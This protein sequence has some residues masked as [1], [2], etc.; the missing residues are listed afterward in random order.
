MTDSAFK[1]SGVA[2]TYYTS[3]PWG[4]SPVGVGG[5]ASPA[6]TVQAGTSYGVSSTVGTDITFAREDHQHG[7]VP[8]D[9]IVNLSA[10]AFSSGEY[11][12]WNGS[13]FVASSAVL[14]TAVWSGVGGA[15]VINVTPN[16]P[17][18]GGNFGPNTVATTTGG[19]KEAVAALSST[20][21][22]TV[23]VNAGTYNFTG[24]VTITTSNVLIDLDPAAIL[25]LPATPSVTITTNSGGTAMAPIFEVNNASNVW[26]RGGVLTQAASTAAT[27]CGVHIGPNASQVYINGVTFLNLNRWAIFMNGYTNGV[28]GVWSYVYE[29]GNTMTSC[30]TTT[31]PDGGG[32]RVANDTGTSN[33]CHHAYLG[34]NDLNT[35]SVYSAYDFNKNT[36]G[37]TSNLYLSYARIVGNGSSTY[38][39]NLENCNSPSPGFATGC[40]TVR[41]DHLDVASCYIG[42]LLG[43]NYFD[44]EMS[45]NTVT[46][47]WLQG[48]KLAFTGSSASLETQHVR[49]SG[50]TVSNSNQAGATASGILIGFDAGISGYVLDDVTLTDTVTFDSQ[51]S[52]TQYYGIQIE[53]LTAGTTLSNVTIRNHNGE[54]NG[55]SAIEIVVPYTG[56][57]TGL[58]FN[59]PIAAVVGPNAACTDFNATSYGAGLTP[60]TPSGV[61]TTTGGFN[62]AQDYLKY[63]GGGV[64]Q[65]NGPIT[66]AGQYCFRN[67]VATFGNNFLMT[68]TSTAACAIPFIT[69]VDIS[70]QS[71]S[72]LL[73][74]QVSPGNTP[75]LDTV[76]AVGASPFT[77][78]NASSFYQVITV[79]GGTVSSITINGTLCANTYA[80]V[81]LNPGGAMVV[82]YSSA[83]TMVNLSGVMCFGPANGNNYDVGIQSTFA[84]STTNGFLGTGWVNSAGSDQGNCQ[85]NHFLTLTMLASPSCGL[86][87][88]RA[89]GAGGSN[90]DAFVNNQIDLL[91]IHGYGESQTAPSYGLDFACH[92]D[93]NQ[94]S[95]YFAVASQN[96]PSSCSAVIF[97]DGNFTAASVDTRVNNNYIGVLLNQGG[98]VLA[99]AQFTVVANASG[100]ASEAGYN[101]VRRFTRPGTETVAVQI[102]N[103]ARF[104]GTDVGQG[105]SWNGE[106]FATVTNNIGVAPSLSVKNLASSA[107][108]AGTAVVI[109]GLSTGNNGIP[110]T[111]NISGICEV[112]ACGTATTSSAVAA[113]TLQLYHTLSPNGTQNGAT[114]GYTSLGS[115][116]IFKAQG[117]AS[118]C[119]FSLTALLPA[120]VAIGSTTYFDIGQGTSS[121]LDPVSISAV[122]FSVKELPA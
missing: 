25:K 24:I 65:L 106:G 15:P 113:I 84:A 32:V 121:T 36:T 66:G 63:I 59:S 3:A 16:G 38:G 4:N 43:G 40:S 20:G 14:S 70:V 19:I 8:H 100:V 34:V 105:N 55:K 6:T 35:G 107:Y 39:V 37:P 101:E 68:S 72:D 11:P 10:S 58:V 85:S 77:Y 26:I 86:Y 56:T 87:G 110:Y 61:L 79:I 67:G 54:G 117:A 114:T 18:D 49:L 57:V 108:S 103:N 97:N 60:L 33:I 45:D 122:D 31:I 98:A 7:T 47:S 69:D 29:W 78:T 80:N 41:L 90:N 46:T 115:A 64:V 21:G 52:P 119:E 2:S 120:A 91:Q 71:K 116:K 17:T 76:I 5:T 62:E 42:V 48:I 12:Q 82:H 94:I 74:I 75:R 28:A 22:G 96:S 23:H 83:P 44:V 27:G 95:T 104:S 93:S 88:F 92:C 111:P 81:A 50:N 112:T 102:N 13:E 51:A 9:N 99:S 109:C 1:S 89:V 30:G 118:G 73:G 53:N